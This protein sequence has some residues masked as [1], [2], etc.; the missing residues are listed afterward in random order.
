MLECYNKY[1]L[2][3][4]NCCWK[5]NKKV[6]LSKGGDHEIFRT[7]KA[8]PWRRHRITT[9]LSWS[10]W[11]CRLISSN[12]PMLSNASTCFNPTNCSF[13]TVSQLFFFCARQSTGLVPSAT[14]APGSWPISQARQSLFQYLASQSPPDK[15]WSEFPHLQFRGHC[16]RVCTLNEYNTCSV[17]RWQVETYCMTW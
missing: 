3:S 14:S 9:R 6:V 7:C 15:L 5:V 10:S 13:Q 12:D 1:C 2:K 4:E 16:H 11:P 17:I 8:R